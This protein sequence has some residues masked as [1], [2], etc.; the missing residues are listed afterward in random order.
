MIDNKK[1]KKEKITT[2]KQ[3]LYIAMKQINYKWKVIT[4]IIANC[5]F[6]CLHISLFKINMNLNNIPFIKDLN[7]MTLNGL[8]II[9]DVNIIHCIIYIISIVISIVS[10]YGFYMLLK[11]LSKPYKAKTITGICKDLKI[12]Y[13][14]KSK[15]NLPIPITETKDKE[16]SKITQMELYS[17]G[18]TIE[19]WEKEDRLKRFSQKF[20]RAVVGVEPHETD[21][22]KMYLYYRKDYSEKTLFWKNSYLINDDC[23]LVLGENGIGKQETINLNDNPFLVIAGSSGSGKSIEL[24]SLLMQNILKGN[25]VI[26]GEFSK[27]GVDFNKY[28]RNLKN[29]T[30]YTELDLF[31]GLF[32]YELSHELDVRK[33]LL[34]I[35]NCKNISD[36]NK[37]IETG[38]IKGEKLQRIIIALD[39]AGQ[40]FTKSNDK[41]TEETLKYIR[42]NINKMFSTYRYC[43]IHAILATQVPSASIFT[44]E[45]RYNSDRICGKANKILSEMAIDSP[46]ASTISK[47]SKG[48]FATSWGT[49]FQGYLFFEKDVF[50][51]CEKQGAD[52]N[53]HTTDN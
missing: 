52:S 1:E 42:Y 23:T 35:N 26:I 46:K 32:G 2:W 25:R 53:E 39:E 14:E 36:Y 6:I 17:N 13:G 37:K 22:D 44:E 34:R 50:K 45:V 8:P 9:G 31:E 48:H 18:T 3:D 43:G 24:M 19:D 20:S 10:I 38:E 11:A 12:Y 27:G 33:E 49:E 40:I 41:K 21:I 7:N 30:I 29:C 51:N 15:R 16:N 28:W 4:M 47:K 5:I